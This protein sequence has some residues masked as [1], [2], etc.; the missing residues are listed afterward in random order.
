[1]LEATITCPE[2]G[3]REKETMPTDACVHFYECR[4]SGTLLKPRAGD[5]FVFWSYADQP[6]PPVQQSRAAHR[7]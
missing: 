4:G 1:M 2:R 3:H 6:C 7:G 5:C